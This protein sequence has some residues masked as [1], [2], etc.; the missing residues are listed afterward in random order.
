M[1]AIFSGT[2]SFKLHCAHILPG[3]LVKLQILTQEVCSGTWI[4]KDPLFHDTDAPGLRTTL[5]AAKLEGCAANFG[6]HIKHHMEHLETQF[7]D[8]IPRSS[9]WVGLEWGLTLCVTSSTTG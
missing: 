4:S 3:D 5:G 7:L 8:L 6:M 1:Q 2:I 9:A